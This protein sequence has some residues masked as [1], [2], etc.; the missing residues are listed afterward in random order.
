MDG[1][2][3]IKLTATVEV[4]RTMDYLWALI[5]DRVTPDEFAEL[6]KKLAITST[7]HQSSSDA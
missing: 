1:K 4:I 3:K 2:E 5:K 6:M 7:V